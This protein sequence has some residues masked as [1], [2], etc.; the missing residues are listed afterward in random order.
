MTNNTGYSRVVIG[1][2]VVQN[3]TVNS[4][5]SA[6]RRGKMANN[7]IAS[8]IGDRSAIKEH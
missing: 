2:V 1:F 4:E 5:H 6:I 8:S 3:R 7:G